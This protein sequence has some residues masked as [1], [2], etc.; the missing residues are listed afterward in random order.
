MRLPVES[1]RWLRPSG[2]ISHR[3]ARG[4]FK[5]VWGIFLGV[6]HLF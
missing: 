5:G 4:G 6:F 2:P 1:G 3:E